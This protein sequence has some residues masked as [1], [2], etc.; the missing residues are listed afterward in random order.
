MNNI[1]SEIIKLIY[2]E[3]PLP[4]EINKD[5]HLHDLGFDSLSFFTLILKIEELFSIEI[6]ISEMEDCLFVKNLIFIVEGK[7]KGGTANA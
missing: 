4:I 3:A 6:R 5:C 2:Q 7:V 1:E